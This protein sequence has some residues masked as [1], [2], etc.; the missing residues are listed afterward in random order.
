MFLTVDI[1]SGAG[2]SSDSL[3][4]VREHSEFDMTS[5]RPWDGDSPPHSMYLAEDLFVRRR[6]GIC[7]RR[8]AVGRLYRVSANGERCAKPRKF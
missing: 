4:A 2:S 3:L 8:G 5:S 6:D 1:P 7:C